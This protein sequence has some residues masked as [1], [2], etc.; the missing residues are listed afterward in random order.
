MVTIFYIK[1]KYL[2]SNLMS[3]L[4][5]IWQKL[6]TG[7]D[8]N[9][10]GLDVKTDL[11]LATR[12]KSL[13]KEKAGSV[14]FTRATE[15]NKKNL[16]SDSTQPHRGLPIH[17]SSA[18]EQGR[19][20]SLQEPQVC[21]PDPGAGVERKARDTSAP[22]NSNQPSTA[23]DGWHFPTISVMTQHTVLHKHLCSR[24]HAYFSQV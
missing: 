15:N 20:P 1:N 7:R 16:K 14:S 22:W 17:H 10:T 11:V 21:R 6:G 8:N 13:E 4:S 5:L 24:Q 9:I 23:Q 18:A 2:L 19:W 3:K 12:S